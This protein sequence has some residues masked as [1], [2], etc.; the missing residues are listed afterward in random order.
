V[1][2]Y[3]KRTLLE[4]SDKCVSNYPTASFDNQVHSLSCWWVHKW[5]DKQVYWSCKKSW[6]LLF[7]L[8]LLP[9]R[10][11][12]GGGLIGNITNSLANTVALDSTKSERLRFDFL[13]S[14]FITS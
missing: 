2:W 12:T 1:I 14:I 4:E 10:Q 3:I 11:A 7:L 6:R 8:L 9:P 13:V 5:R